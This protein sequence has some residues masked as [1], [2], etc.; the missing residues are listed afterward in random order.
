MS[1]KTFQFNLKCVSW[2]NV[3][4]PF[5]SN[6]KAYTMQHSSG[7]CTLLKMVPNRVSTIDDDGVW[8]LVFEL[9]QNKCKSFSFLLVTPFGVH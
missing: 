3:F 4:T 9:T 1:S 5:A 6:R 2:K 7:Q 8:C